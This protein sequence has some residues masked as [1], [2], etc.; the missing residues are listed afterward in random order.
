MAEGKARLYRYEPGR[1]KKYTVPILIVYAPIL[2][3]YILDLA[4]GRSFTAYLSDEGFDVYLLDCGIPGPEDR[5]LSFENWI[6]DYMPEAVQSVLDSSRA[7]ELS[8]FRCCQSGTMN[9]MY[10]S[11]FPDRP[12]KNLILLATPVDFAPENPGLLGLWTLW[13][14]NSENYFDPD[15]M[16]EAFGNILEDFLQRLVE[17]GDS[18]LRPLPA[19]ADSYAKLWDSITPENTMTSWLAVCK[20]VDDGTP[21]P[22]EAF[23][24]WSREFYQQN[25]LPKG[26]LELGG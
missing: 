19:F 1:E 14:R 8:I 12:L 21:F 2:R 9:A 26:E 22:G 18:M 6:L 15:L 24:Q 3:S 5:Y 16:V 25:R 17:T 20:W 10:A 13:S 23:R 11:L 7:E 4:P